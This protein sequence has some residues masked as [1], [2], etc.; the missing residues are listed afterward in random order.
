MAIPVWLWPAVATVATVAGTAISATGSV[1]AGNAEAEA[2]R[3]AQAANEYNA[4]LAEAQALSIRIAGQ[5][6]EL[7]AAEDVRR[8]MGSQIAAYGRAGVTLEGS[9][10]EML[11]STAEEG[12]LDAL[13]I[14]YAAS[15]GSL[16]MLDQAR[17]GRRAGA[18]AARAGLFAQ[19]ASR[20]EAGATLLAGAGN[21]AARWRQPAG[22]D[23]RVG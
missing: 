1:Q 22:N 7:R 16:E 10:S 12:R 21:L 20:Y 15:Q 17:Q 14:R 2:G 19:Q 4:R 13:A 18:S 23:L 6:E 5:W 3:A 9:P 11:Q 8:V